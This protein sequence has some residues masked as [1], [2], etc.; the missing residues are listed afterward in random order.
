MKQLNVHKYKTTDPSYVLNKPA[1][2]SY[3]KDLSNW[4]FMSIKQLILLM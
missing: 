4:T 3:G 1:A 2:L